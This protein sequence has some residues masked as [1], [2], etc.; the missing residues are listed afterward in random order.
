[1]ARMHGGRRPNEKAK[2]FKGTMKKLIR[3]MAIYKVQVF[4]VAVFAICGTIFNIVGP[5]ILGKATT[6]IFN[7]LVSKVSGGD[8]MNFG[9]IG[10]I[11]L[12]VLC[13]YVISAICSFV[14]GYLMTGVSQKTTY[15][16]RREISEKIN[17]MPM[18]YFDTK[19]VGEVLSRVT[20]DVEAL[21]E[22]YSGILVQLF[23]NIVKIVGLA[24]V[25]L[26]LD[27]RLAAISF[28]LMPLVIGLT[29]LCQKIARNIY[30]LYR[31]RLTDIN[32]FLSEHLSGMKIIQIFGRQERKFEEF[33]DKNTK[34]YK[35]FYR[36]MLMYAVFRPLIYILSILSLMIVLWF[37]SR[38]VF[39]EIISVGT[40]YISRITS[41]HFRPTTGTCRAVF[42]TAVINCIRQ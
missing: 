28:V 39:D 23:R 32:T 6:E 20:N 30:R 42:D 19:P 1:M 37:G 3:Y 18:S 22:M 9:K 35:A 4:F 14:Q 29:V 38:N 7:G 2:D 36:E 34:L 24:G 8:G 40:L 5:K 16:L 11:L 15:R 31:T 33:H 12:A 41:G 17:R 10:Q 13:L 27:V 25:M 26:V 21:N